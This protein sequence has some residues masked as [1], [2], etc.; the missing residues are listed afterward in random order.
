MEYNKTNTYLK[1]DKSRMVNLEYSLKREILRTNR[2]GAYHCTTLVEC[3][4]RKQH[5][6]LVMPVPKLDNSNH[7]L[8]S[9]F[10]ETVIQHGAEFNLGI[11]KYDGNN[12]SPMGHKYIREFNCESLPQTI[13]RVGGVVLAKEKMFSLNGNTIYIRYT[14]L[15]AHSPTTIRFRPFL[16]FREINQLTEENTV[17]EHGYK[18]VENGIS[19]CMYSGYPELFMQ[20]NKEAKFIFHPSWYKGIEYEEDKMAGLPYKEDLYVPGYF[21][22]PIEKG[23]SIIFSAS[24]TTADTAN[25]LSLFEEGIKNRTPRS[26]F[27]NCL[28]NSGHQFYFRPSADELYLLNGYPY[29]KVTA[30]EQFMALPGLTLGIERPEAFEQIMDTAIPAIEAFM[31]GEPVSGFLKDISNAD[32]LLWIIK[33]L[34]KFSEY[35][36]ERFYAKYASLVNRLVAF[37][38]EG[39]HPEL[40]PLANGLLS[41][42]SNIGNP[43]W[44]HH[45]DSPREARPPRTGLLVE[46]NAAWYSALMFNRDIAH[47]LQDEKLE[48]KMTANAEIVK[49]SFLE[50][51]L[52]DGGYL[53]DYVVGN[54][55]DWSVRPNMLLAIASDY[56]L[57]DKRQSKSIIDIV[58][59]ELLTAKGLRT[60]SPKSIGFR[61]RVEGSLVDRV[62]SCYNGAAWPWLLA[63]YL[64][65]YLKI[66]QRS[67]YSFLDRLLIGIEEEMSNDCI[68]SLSALYDGSIPY[69]GHGPISYAINIAGVLRALDI[70]QSFADE[71]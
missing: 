34:K 19:M 13:Y 48:K 30:R 15:D 41:V 65:A 66:F 16:A 4:T 32:V 22:L 17:A 55:V 21:E 42:D 36:H 25:L 40:T 18:E 9:S 5:G 10:D 2:R 56:P 51:F 62:Y 54:Y 38:Q 31:K 7:V 50:V 3:N 64:E 43:S 60:L 12:Y 52:N 57:L 33:D 45:A 24:D 28:K 26:S 49:A 20:F 29:G 63:S 59:K 35:D 47:H 53:Y 67:G 61:P 37:I 46:V 70:Q 68:G 27:Y 23:E 39:N 44:M 69:F 6:L 71:Y 1:F 14:L 58:T 8:L 11:H